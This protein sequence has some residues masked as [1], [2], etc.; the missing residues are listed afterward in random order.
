MLLENG[1]RTKLQKGHRY[2]CTTTATAQGLRWN[3]E[4]CGIVCTWVFGFSVSDRPCVVW[5]RVLFVHGDTETILFHFLH[6]QE[7]SSAHLLVTQP[8]E[9]IQAETFPPLPF[10]AQPPARTNLGIDFIWPCCNDR[11]FK[12]WPTRLITGRK[13]CRM[14]GICILMSKQRWNA[15]IHA[16]SGKTVGNLKG[17]QTMMGFY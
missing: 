3:Y 17:S 4:S 14:A 5:W 2:P 8:V 12:L 9:I 13:W 10:P 15:T 1:R 6:V 7:N 16:H 11:A